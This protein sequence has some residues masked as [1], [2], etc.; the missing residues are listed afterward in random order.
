[1][2]QGAL[3]EAH[4]QKIPADVRN[5][6]GLPLGA[7]SIRDRVVSDVA[8]E[9]SLRQEQADRANNEALATAEAAKSRA[10]SSCAATERRWRAAAEERARVMQQWEKVDRARAAEAAAAARESQEADAAILRA[11]KV[12]AKPGDKH[13]QSGRVPAATAAVA[14]SP[15]G[16]PAV[17][18]AENPHK[19]PGPYPAA[20]SAETPIQASGP[21]PVAQP[22]PRLPLPTDLGQPLSQA[23]LLLR[24]PLPR[25]LRSTPLRRPE[26]SLV[27]RPPMLWEPSRGGCGPFRR[28]DIDHL[29][30]RSLPGRQCPL[31]GGGGQEYAFRHGPGGPGH[32]RQVRG[33]S[34]GS[35]VPASGSAV[36]GARRE[37]QV[38]PG[39]VFYP[40]PHRHRAR[41]L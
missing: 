8:R 33:S 3:A 27:R 26:S 2:F 24:D 12:L 18:A 35:A 10:I 16:V 5:C 40:E 19:A 11:K 30:G 36:I 39:F 9:S 13:R 23:H 1:M 25:T 7:G 21:Y 29:E 41:P 31:H 14:P 28:G 17:V 37:R 15:L 34:I 32:G 22:T 38:G 6:L 20:V 4:W